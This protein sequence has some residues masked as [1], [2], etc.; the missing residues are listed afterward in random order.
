MCAEANPL[1]SNKT[2]IDNRVYQIGVA[3]ADITPPVGIRLIGY[4][5]R[6]GLSRGIDEPLTATVLLVRGSGAM[7]AIVAHDWCFASMGFATKLRERCGIVL[8]IPPSNVLINFNHTHSAPV[9]P[10]YLPYDT[11]EQLAMQAR[12]GEEMSVALERACREAKAHLRPARLAV[13]WGDCRANI[14]RREKLADGTV[15]LGENPA[16]PCDQRVGV[17]RLDGLDGNPLAVVFRYSCHTVTLGPKT[18]LISPDYAGAARTVIE[19]TMGC[20]SLFLQGC[21]GNMNPVT[22][23]GQDSDESP[24]VCEDKNR[25]GQMLGGEVI[26]VCATLRTHRRRTEPQLVQSV[27]PYWL[28]GYENIPPDAEG[29]VRAMETTLTLPLVPFPSLTEVQLEREQYAARLANAESNGARECDWRVAKRF[30]LWAQRRLNAATTGPNPWLISVPLQTIEIGDIAFI[31]APMELMAETG[32]SLCSAFPKR[33]TFVLGY[34]NGM[35]SYLPTPEVSRE[36][37]MESKLAYKHYLV[38]AEIPGDWEPQIREAAVN[39][40]KTKP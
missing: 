4:T 36:G 8:D 15:M 11:L 21:A 26:K 10:D 30:D 3:R 20:P 7:V 22:G 35:I 19:R 27:A 14:N 38:P 1:S 5:V 16:G 13:G 6:E 2:L 37:G 17:L 9:V 28:Y 18:N 31:A 29:S 25:I 23:I 24:N 34:S 12:H 32:M 40:L 39:L 33:T